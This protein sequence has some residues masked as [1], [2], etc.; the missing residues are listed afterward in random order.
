MSFATAM[1]HE[2]D[3]PAPKIK[4]RRRGFLGFDFSLPFDLLEDLAIVACLR[5]G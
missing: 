1:P 3:T 5:V 4:T 2:A